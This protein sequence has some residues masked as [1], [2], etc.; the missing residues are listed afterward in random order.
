MKEVE[1]LSI[2]GY[3]FTV[4]QDAATLLRDYIA[5]LEKHYLPQAD[6][7]EIRIPLPPFV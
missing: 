2:G 3:A 7:K 1:R 4:E 5:S 6:G